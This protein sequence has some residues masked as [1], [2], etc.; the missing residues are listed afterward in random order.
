[1]TSR[2]VQLPRYNEGAISDVLPAILAAIGVSGEPDVLGLPHARGY[3]VLLIDGLGWNQL[4]RHPAEAPFLASLLPQARPL[5]VGAPSTTATSLTSFGTGLPPGRHGV[6]G[7][8]SRRPG[9]TDVLLNALIWDPQVDPIAYQPHPTVFERAVA[10]HV[11]VSVVSKRQFRDSGL[12]LAGLRGP[13]FRGAD[14]LGERVAAVAEE[15]TTTAPSLIYVY[16]GDLDYTGHRHGCSSAA[17]RHQLVQLDRFAEQIYDEL[18]PGTGLVVT[19]DHGMIDVPPECRIDVDD[20][21]ELRDGVELIGGEARFRHVYVKPGALA[22]VRASWEDI[23]GDRAIVVSREEAIAAGWFGA[24]ERRVL[25]RIGDLVVVSRDAFAIE[26]RSVFPF[27]A[28]LVGLHGAF[29]DDEL[30]VPLLVAAG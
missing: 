16:D 7:Y 10:A 5:S 9:T 17:W 28:K 11:S 20:K 19:A 1:V 30:L 13:R 14:A 27:E 29:S 26:L 15:L 18:G 23:V 12:T 21:P 24:V 2:H 3:C 8:T 25:D 22:D 6:V 4:R